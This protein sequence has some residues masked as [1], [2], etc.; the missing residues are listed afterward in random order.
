MPTPDATPYWRLSGFYL[1]YFASLG[2]LIPFW[3]L[4]LQDLGHDAAAI[5]ELMALLLATKI[6]APNLWGWLAD[7]RGERVRIVRAASLAALRTGA[8]AALGAAEAPGTTLLQL[9][10]VVRKPGIVE[11]PTGVT[12]REV[13]E[14]PKN[15][16]TRRFLRAV[17]H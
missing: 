4:Y 5:G 6:I 16:R 2:A 11:V 9:G 17:E 7:R 15:E 3:G 8:Y 13:L 14:S 12:I 10:G 1:V